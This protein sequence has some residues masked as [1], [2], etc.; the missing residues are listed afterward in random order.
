[1]TDRKTHRAEQIL[2]KMRKGDRK[3]VKRYT[4]PPD[5][6]FIIQRTTGG[7][8]EKILDDFNQSTLDKVGEFSASGITSISGTG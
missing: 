4:G 7:T 5:L 3:Q 6:D 8:G 2:R 1:M